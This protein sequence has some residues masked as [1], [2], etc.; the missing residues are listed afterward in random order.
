MDQARFWM[1]ASSKSSLES[2]FVL[3][4]ASSWEE[5]AFAQDAAGP[6][7]AF[8]WPPRSYSCSFCGREFKSAQALGGHMNVHRRERAKL[9]QSPISERNN[10]HHQEYNGVNYNTNSR[11]LLASLSSVTGSTYD[12]QSML[13]SAIQDH[14]KRP[15]YPSH[16]SSSDAAASSR[17]LN[18]LESKI[19]EDYTK[20]QSDVDSLNLSVGLGN[21]ETAC[22]KRRRTDGAPLMPFFLNTT[23]EEVDL[24]LRLGPDHP[25]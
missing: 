8:I 19:E 15:F 23:T 24:E 12:I 10:L 1:W 2:S 13:L 20:K 6:F 7:G 3:P 25:N 16:S 17:S 4:G 22:Y 21:R 14:Q 5:E 11:E 18:I 9:K